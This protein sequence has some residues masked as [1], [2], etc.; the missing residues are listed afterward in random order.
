VTPFQTYWVHKLPGHRVRWGCIWFSP[1]AWRVTF[2]EAIRPIL[3]KTLLAALIIEQTLLRK[4]MKWSSV[5]S[6]NQINAEIQSL[7]DS[8][9][10]PNADAYKLVNKDVYIKFDRHSP[11]LLSVIL[12][13]DGHRVITIGPM[14]QQSRVGTPK[15]NIQGPIH[16]VL[17]F[18]FV[19]YFNPCRK[20]NKVV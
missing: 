8:Q 10:L 14:R 19:F 18:V 16:L 5:H 2:S 7:F 4:V 17:S 9:P 20:V 12:Q 3:P 15:H 11:T 6:W 13:T 1:T